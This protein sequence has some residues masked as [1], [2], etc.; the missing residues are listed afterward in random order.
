MKLT[1]STTLRRSRFWVRDREL[2]ELDRDDVGDR[3]LAGL[4]RREF[5]A[6][7]QLG[8]FVRR[9]G[10]RIGDLGDRL[11]LADHRDRIGVLEDFVELVG[12]EDDRRALG[13]EFAE[14]GEQLVDLLGHEHSGGFVQDQDL[15]ASVQHLEDLHTLL[16][17]DAEFGDQRVGVDLQTVL[18]AEFGDPRA[19]RADVER[20]CSAGFLTEDD[21]LPDGQV[22][23]QHERLEDHSDALGDGVL[24]R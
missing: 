11:A 23:C 10:A 9:D 17:A 4:R 2:A 22:G 6:D 19:G 12:D 18:H 5:A 8:E 3:A 24:G 20:H 21:V 16:V 7:H 13:G 1:S 14:R 15:G